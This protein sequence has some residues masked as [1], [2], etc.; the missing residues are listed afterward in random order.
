MICDGGKPRCAVKV[1]STVSTATIPALMAMETR[2]MSS[3]KC[4]ADEDEDITIQN[5]TSIGSESMNETDK[6]ILRIMTTK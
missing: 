6:M 2:V 5:L 3:I 1:S 4:I